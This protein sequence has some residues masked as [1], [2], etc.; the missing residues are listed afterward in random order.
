MPKHEYF[1]W[2]VVPLVHLQMSAGCAG[3]CFR[4]KTCGQL[5]G[6]LPAAIS[7][8]HGGVAVPGAVRLSRIALVQTDR[9]Y[10]FG[11][12]TSAVLI[13]LS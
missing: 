13:S 1:D 3:L 4:G 9:R 10:Y 8:G 6:D 2:A 12:R 11:L 7:V 5:L